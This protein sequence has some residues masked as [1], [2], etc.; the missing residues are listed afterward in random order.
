M[1]ANLTPTVVLDFAAAIAVVHSPGQFTCH[2]Q[3]LY[4]GGEGSAAGLERCC[5][6]EFKVHVSPLL[7]LHDID[8]HPDRRYAGSLSMMIFH[9]CACVRACVRTCAVLCCE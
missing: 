4:T 6:M 5:H 8:A 1:F 9:R 7:E 2:C 3:V